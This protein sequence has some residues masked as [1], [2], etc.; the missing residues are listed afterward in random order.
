MDFADAEFIHSHQ[1]ADNIYNRIDGAH[2]VKM[3][4]LNGDVVHRAFG[5]RKQ[6]YG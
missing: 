4:L 1:G 5:R 3:N 2:F 6:S